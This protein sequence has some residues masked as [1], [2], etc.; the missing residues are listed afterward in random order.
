MNNPTPISKITEKEKKDQVDALNVLS[1]KGSKE[2]VK[3]VFTD[4]ETEKPLTYAQMR[5]RYG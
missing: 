1:N 4:R 2:F 5:E 3:Y